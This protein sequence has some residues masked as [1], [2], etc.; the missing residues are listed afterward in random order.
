MTIQNPTAGSIAMVLADLAAQNTALAELLSDD[1]RSVLGCWDAVAS[2]DRA[3]VHLGLV[4]GGP[5]YRVT[6]ERLDQ[7]LIIAPIHQVFRDQYDTLVAREHGLSLDEFRA[8]VAAGQTFAGYHS[9]QEQ[10]A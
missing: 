5:V 9:Y 2:P 3:T 7:D 1:P 10:Q 6:V 4:E 8:Q